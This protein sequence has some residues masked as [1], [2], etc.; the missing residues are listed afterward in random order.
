LNKKEKSDLQ[1]EKNDVEE[2]ELN[3]PKVLIL[4]G[5]FSGTLKKLFLFGL[6]EYFST[7]RKKYLD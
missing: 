4:A 7:Y 3:L 2:T 6:I 1:N 5:I